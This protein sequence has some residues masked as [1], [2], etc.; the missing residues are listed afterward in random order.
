MHRHGSQ[1]GGCRTLRKRPKLRARFTIKNANSPQRRK[2]RTKEVVRG[3]HVTA[4][5]GSV[6]LG[7]GV[8]AP[9]FT[10]PAES[11]NFFLHGYGDGVILQFLAL[12][13]LVL[14]VRGRLD[15][16][17]LT[18]SASLEWLVYTF[19]TLRLQPSS[20]GMTWGW[21]VLVGGGALLVASAVTRDV[22]TKSIPLR[23]ILVTGLVTVGI[24]LAAWLLMQLPESIHNFYWR[25]F[26]LVW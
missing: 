19:I 21:A 15:W 25:K 13:S 23:V 5:V 20:L 6:A 12:V 17:L 1:H 11:A 18:G 10:L 9:A 16:L 7:A 3:R 26:E 2:P 22:P 8:F 24:P 14:V 4:L